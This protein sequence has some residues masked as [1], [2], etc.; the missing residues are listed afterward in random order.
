[1]NVL[2]DTHSFLWMTQDKPELSSRARAAI[3]DPSIQKF[4]SMVSLWELAIKDGL[5]KVELRAPLHELL[6]EIGN[7]FPLHRLG[8]QD[9]HVLAYRNLALHH[10]DPF[11]RM[12]IAQALSENLA[13]V[14]NDE[15]FDAYGVLRIW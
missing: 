10:R 4:V 13:V 15:A 6:A 14:G 9:A 3:S 8:I 1:M 5:G 11:D 12:L 7:P 2:L